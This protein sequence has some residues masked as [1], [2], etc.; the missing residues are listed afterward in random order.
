MRCWLSTYREREIDIDQEFG[1][2]SKAPKDPEAFDSPL[3]N[4]Q[5]YKEQSC[6][7]LGW[8]SWYA[9][10]FACI[11]LVTN[12]HH[13]S[14]HMHKWASHQETTWVVPQIR[15][16]CSSR[17]T[18]SRANLITYR[19]HL[20]ACSFLSFIIDSRWLPMLPFSLFFRLS[21]LQTQLTLSKRLYLSHQHRYTLTQSLSSALSFN[22]GMVTLEKHFLPF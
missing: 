22:S 11:L 18:L 3:N 9:N 7:K 8:S 17:W 5:G 1:G 19:S 12:I 20:T 2:G 14:S 10:Q 16:W 6:P 13:M 4:N 21:C 15:K